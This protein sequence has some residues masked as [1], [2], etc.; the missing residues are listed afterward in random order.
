MFR[1]EA[2]LGPGQH[3]ARRLY[4]GSLEREP[5]ATALLFLGAGVAGGLYGVGTIPEAR[6]QGIGRAMTVVPLLEA[7]AMGYRIG[8]LHTSPMGEGIYRRLGFREYC[9][10]GR[11]VWRE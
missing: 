7:R 8:V 9:K 3:P 11:Y 5:V 4:L 2:D 1:I 10:L 6:R